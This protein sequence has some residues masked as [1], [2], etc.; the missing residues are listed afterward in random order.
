MSRPTEPTSTDRRRILRD[1]IVASLSRPG[2]PAPGASLPLA[3]D[4][5]RE[6]EPFPL[7]DVQQAYWVGRSAEVAL[8]G[9]ACHGYLELDLPDL[10]L[11]RLEAACNALVA[12]HPMLRAVVSPT[13]EQRILPEV[14]RYRVAMTD[15]VGD[16]AMLDRV[17]T[18]MSH[19]VL[20]TDR[21]PLFDIRVTRIGDGRSRLHLS[22]DILIADARSFGVLAEEL[23]ALYADGGRSLPPI[24]IGFRDYVMALRRA[25]NGEE[26]R[27]HLAYWRDRLDSMPSAPQLPY[28]AGADQLR[29][30]RFERLESRLTAR[31]WAA[32]RS[33]AAALHAGPA[34]LVLT[35]FAESIGYWAADSRFTLS[36][37]LFDRRPLHPDIDRV[38]GPFTN[39]TLVDVDLAGPGPV[40]NL[41]GRVQQRLWEALERSDVSGVRVLRE[42]G[43]RQ[44]EPVAVPVVFT[45]TGDG[46]PDFRTSFGAAGEVAYAISQ[47]PQVVLDCQVSPT[48][49]GLDLWWDAVGEVFQP[50]VL[51]AM[52]ETFRRAVEALADGFD[53]HGTRPLVAGLPAVARLRQQ[54]EQTAD[55]P[56]RPLHEMVAAADTAP[57]MPVV[58]GADGRV[59]HAELTAAATRVATALTALGVARGELVAVAA[60]RGWRQ[61][62]AVLGVLRAGAAYLP[63]D[64][65]L[66]APRAGQLAELGGI[67]RL[68][69]ADG[70][71]EWA[72]GLDV[73]AVGPDGDIDP[74]PTVDTSVDDL[75]YVIYTSGST[76]VPKGVLIRHGAAA[77]TL[78]DINN[79]YRVGPHDRVLAVSS[80]GFDLSV[81][82]MF[83]V[84]GAGGT[85]ICAPPGPAAKDPV[86]WLDLMQRER[87]TVWNS[88]PALMSMLA[89]L[90]ELRGARLDDLRLV[91]LSGDWIPVSLPDRIRAF[92]PRATVVS[93]GGATEAS[94]WSVAYDVADVDPGWTSIPY[95][96]PLTNQ[97]LYVLDWAA[98]E[99]PVGVDGELYVGGAGVA[100][101]YWNEPEQTRAAFVDVP[102]FGR[103][104][105]TGDLVHRRADGV[106]VFRGRRDGQ[107][108]IQGHRIE[109]AEID[110]AL[111]R[112]PYVNAAVSA[113]V[114]APD[115]HPQLVASVVPASTGTTPEQI[116]AAL[117][118]ELPE[119]LVP[120]HIA[121]VGEI[122]VTANG[123]VDRSFTAPAPRDGATVHVDG[124]REPGPFARRLQD[125]IVGQLGT[126]PIGIDDNLMLAGLDS[127]DL[128][129]IGGT[130]E[131]EWGVRPAL[132]DVLREPTVAAVDR[133]MQQRILDRLDGGDRLAD[134]RGTARSSARMLVDPADREAFRRRLAE[135]PRIGAASTRRHRLPAWPAQ[136]P[137][138]PE[139]SHFGADPVEATAVDRLCGLLARPAATVARAYV[140]PGDL[141]RTQA[142]VSCV[143]VAGLSGLY[144]VDC[145]RAELVLLDADHVMSED[146]FDPFVYRRVAREAAFAFV[147]VAPVADYQVLY[148]A[149]GAD[150]AATEV[151]AMVQT[152]RLGAGPGLSFR[153]VPIIDTEPLRLD[154]WLDPG[155]AVLH[156]LLGGPAAGAGDDL[157][158]G[159]L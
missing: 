13:G 62:A 80:I 35:A 50:D 44:G 74:G 131:Q 38:V 42:W 152:L 48:A 89:D 137:I 84:L 130:L 49:D 132:E 141:G 16:A 105:R 83:G 54:T 99:R 27:G 64:P 85:V 121:L 79:R 28:A 69:V 66:P 17:R 32:L 46:G 68:V 39:L 157:R 150:F 20:A 2:L 71:P 102:D 146:A 143:R 142:L 92:A 116:R 93:L 63:I 9:V 139:A 23:L 123:K 149:R 111:A 31:Q 14:P 73:V 114:R 21:W 26:Q 108:K 37:T 76:G 136:L 110:T 96:L 29:R 52:F 6:F 95:S 47:T 104:Y 1:T 98:R 36:V 155:D 22:I 40:A 60:D 148:G 55:L 144:V 122:P 81:W 5:A 103:C 113:V 91:L 145:D 61:I 19:Q 128:V 159:V 100:D 4:P 153:S 65:T 18:E 72:A 154:R 156:V 41:V 51:P 53:P 78:A 140:T 117:A 109:L 57:R 115:G 118:A 77:N 90:A 158:E 3:P 75:A 112:L 151:G 135:S 82:D 101:G 147:F 125:Q 133:L 10:E 107:V 58:I 119:Y 138:P 129:R 25:Q 34:A 7:L 67:R 120:V 33:A 94:V 11:P 43:R 30:P 56:V 59:T 134:G 12:R 70:P 88:V 124:P 87:V 106:L 8:G 86:R 97:R 45:Y 24:G 127:V 15:A 126:G